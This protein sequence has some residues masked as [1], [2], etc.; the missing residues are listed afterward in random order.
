MQRQ[1]ESD[2]INY[3]FVTIICG[4]C[5]SMDRMPGAGPAPETLALNRISFIN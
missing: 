1:A 5:N 3:K 4:V 2:K